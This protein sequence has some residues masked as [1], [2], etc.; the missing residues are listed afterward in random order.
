MPRSL[1]PLWLALAFVLF[2]AP[3]AQAAD[4]LSIAYGSDPTE[5]GLTP[6]TV[7]W[8]AAESSVRVI[9]T[10]K[11]ASRGCGPTCAADDPYSNDVINRLV[12]PGGSATQYGRL[13]DPG[14]LTL[15]GYLQRADNGALLA[16]T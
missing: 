4:T 5:E 8:S 15:C 7:S 2:G 10:R 12:G 9:L 11:P 16:A 14:T 6:V 3:G 13:N 1:R